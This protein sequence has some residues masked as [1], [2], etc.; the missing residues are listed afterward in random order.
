MN[1]ILCIEIVNRLKNYNLMRIVISALIR[2]KNS[3]VAW[4]AEETM[5]QF[6][7]LL[8]ATLGIRNE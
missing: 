7:N 2:H 5:K 8:H 3:A 4:D 6:T 1:C